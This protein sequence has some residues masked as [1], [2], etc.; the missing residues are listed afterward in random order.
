MDSS[1]IQARPLKIR[2]PSRLVCM[3]LQ[4]SPSVWCGIL[5]IT[6]S[7]VMASEP[8]KSVLDIDLDS[9][10]TVGDDDE[11]KELLESILGY[12]TK[13]RKRH[14][15]HNCMI[16]AYVSLCSESPQMRVFHTE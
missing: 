3:R 9:I 12:T 15:P 11:L 16:D 1:P 4:G 7:A 5:K 14:L 2:H 10:S 6:I 13:H 8:D